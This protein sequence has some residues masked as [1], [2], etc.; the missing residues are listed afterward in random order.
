MTVTLT[1]ICVN[2]LHQPHVTAWVVVDLFQPWLQV[3]VCI[4]YFIYDV[5][6]VFTGL[7]PFA[8]DELQDFTHL[9]ND[10][11]KEHL[12]KPSTL[13]RIYNSTYFTDTETF[14]R[15]FLMNKNV[16]FFLTA[17]CGFPT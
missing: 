9:E 7:L 17:V 3:Y 14:F 1:G 10:Q 8:L 6:K 2:H 13:F 11:R 16:I 5:E 4:T 12:H 15:F